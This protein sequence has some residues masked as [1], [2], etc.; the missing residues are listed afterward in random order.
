MNADDVLAAMKSL[1]ELNYARWQ[2]HA[3][4][5]KPDSQEAG[6]M[7]A[8]AMNAALKGAIDERKKLS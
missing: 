3:E 7:I 6:L 2:E 5:V 1:I 4:P 8:E